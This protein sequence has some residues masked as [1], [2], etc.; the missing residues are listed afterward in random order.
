MGASNKK[1]AIGLYQSVFEQI[2]D[3]KVKVKPDLQNSLK[4]VLSVL[5]ESDAFCKQYDDFLFEVGQVK[6][7][8]E[9]LWLKI[10]RW[11]DIR[12][13]SIEDRQSKFLQD[14]SK[15]QALIHDFLFALKGDFKEQKTNQFWLNKVL[16]L[17]DALQ[18]LNTLFQQLNP[19]KQSHTESYQRV[20]LVIFQ[21][22]SSDEC[23]VKTELEELKNQLDR[24]DPCAKVLQQIDS[25][26]LLNLP[27]S[28]DLAVCFQD[29]EIKQ[30]LGFD[31]EAEQY[32]QHKRRAY[33]ELKRQVNQAQASLSRLLT[34]G[35]LENGQAY[36]NDQ[37]FAELQRNLGD[38]AQYVDDN[39]L[40][41]K[42]RRDE[43]VRLIN[44]VQ[45]DTEIKPE[46]AIK[47]LDCIRTAIINLH[48]YNLPDLAGKLVQYLESIRRELNDGD[49]QI[50]QAIN[51]AALSHD[52][53]RLL[54][55]QATDNDLQNQIRYYFS[56]RSRLDHPE[57]LVEQSQE[58]LA[59]KV[60]NIVKSLSDRFVESSN[61]VIASAVEKYKNII[62]FN[63]RHA[64]YNNTQL[65]ERQL[66]MKCSVNK[67]KYGRACPQF[68]LNQINRLVHETQQPN[69]LNNARALVSAYQNLS[70]GNLNKSKMC[71]EI[72][73]KIDTKISSLQSV[74]AG[75]PF[76]R[77]GNIPTEEKQYS[78]WNESNGY[79]NSVGQSHVAGTE[80]DG[81]QFESGE[82]CNT[83]PNEGDNGHQ[84]T[85]LSYEDQDPA[86]GTSLETNNN[87]IKLIN[88]SQ[89]RISRI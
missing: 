39:N 83:S 63:L 70:D 5:Q 67:L 57:S 62:Q 84:N 14:K 74:E 75:Q 64:I 28:I 38:L 33:A 77:Q 48:Q 25:D 81:N 4:S 87:Q 17:Q 59:S 22:L 51:W 1:L 40:D 10:K 80:F 26:Q 68:V 20:F 47:D 58:E 52:L 50:C 78:H 42:F 15:Q 69:Y 61:S 43:L 36:Q 76:I 18:P 27:Q 89:C 44:N 11:D 12:I 82:E 41:L 24:N 7:N 16:E 23:N 66:D 34:C 73:T 79:P 13:N 21:Y 19:Y 72:I 35:M 29:P 46:F 86:G 49:T 9:N 8:L 31:V 55:P 2:N 88:A 71:S 60:F 53:G 56:D 45:Y 3:P 37:K 65:T 6:D 32:D 54:R 85:S 30:A